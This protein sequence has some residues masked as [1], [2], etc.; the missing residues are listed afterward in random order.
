MDLTVVDLFVATKT[1]ATPSNSKNIIHHCL[2]VKKH[3]Y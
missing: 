2:G 1:R 3:S